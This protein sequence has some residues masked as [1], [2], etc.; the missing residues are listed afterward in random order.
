MQCMLIEVTV[1][2]CPPFYDHLYRQRRII[3][4]AE[5]PE[6]TLV[7]A[8]IREHFTSWV[9]KIPCGDYPSKHNAEFIRWTEVSQGIIDDAK[10]MVAHSDAIKEIKERQ[11]I[12][13]YEAFA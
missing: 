11:L 7:I 5:N 10:E 4:L 8:I 6:E 9:E 12:G 3:T 13:A 1:C 2:D